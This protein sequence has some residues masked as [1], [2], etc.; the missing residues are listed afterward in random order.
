MKKT[1]WVVAVALTIA[2]FSSPA[3]AYDFQIG[4]VF[5]ST[6]SG[7]VQV[8]SNSGTLQT[9]LNTTQGGFT[10]GSAT[11]AAGNFYVT[12]FSS[13]SVS[14]F[15]TQG[16]LTDATFVTG[17]TN[18]ES[19]VFDKA[20]GFYVG[21]AGTTGIKYFNSAGVLQTT[22]TVAIEDRGTDWVD[23]AANQTTLYYTSE[24]DLIK[25]YD[26]VSGQLSDFADLGTGTQ[27]YALRILGDGGVLVADTFDIKRLD[28]A[29][30]VIQAYDVTGQNG[31]FALNL[32]PNGT[33]FWSGDFG[34]G[35]FFEFDIAS[36]ALLNTVSTGSSALYGLS[37]Y[38]EITQGGGGVVDGGRVPEPGTL[39]LLG[40]GLVGLV[41]YRRAKRMM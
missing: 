34:N 37:V 24:G 29:G 4:D 21:D 40:S 28:A 17:G 22:Y 39:L 36:G 7:T 25:R 14:Q 20:G 23:L 33:S 32:D 18:Y 8:Y 13:G 38:G 5:A 31:W 2:V 27:A 9:T 10:T 11:D 41:G 26:T 1:F 15:D 19:I 35:K 16:A 3:M 30:N 12:N 6:G